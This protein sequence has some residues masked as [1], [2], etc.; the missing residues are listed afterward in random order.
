MTRDAKRLV[1]ARGL[2]PFHPPA[3]PL[4][5]VR[6]GS[7][8]IPGVR[9][10]SFRL[11]AA[12]DRSFRVRA[13][14]G[15]SLRVPADRKD[16]RYEARR[17]GAYPPRGCIHSGSLFNC[18]SEMNLASHELNARSVQATAEGYHE[19]RGVAA[20][21]S[22]QPHQCSASQDS[23]GRRKDSQEWLSDYSMVVRL[24]TCCS[25]AWLYWRSIWSSVW[26]FL[27]RSSRRAISVR[28]LTMSGLAVVA[29]KLGDGGAGGAGL[30]VNASARARGQTDSAGRISG[31]LGGMA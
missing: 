23:T 16:S 31:V 4:I 1:I 18:N 11:I 2:W 24:W 29:R 21:Q 20:S 14:G 7:S 5:E 19:H 15:C 30:G 13:A 28:S 12:S 25:R 26:S 22:C 10:F 17:Q 6:G 8:L 3:C 9:G 27:M